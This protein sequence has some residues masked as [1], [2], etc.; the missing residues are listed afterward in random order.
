MSPRN[1]QRKDKP[2]PNRRNE[3]EKRTSRFGKEKKFVKKSFD[4][5]NDEKPYKSREKKT[6]R[7]SDDD[8][9][10]NRFQKDKPRSFDRNENKK[11]YKHRD[12]RKSYKSKPTQGNDDFSE[13]NDNKPRR[14]SK[15]RPKPYG[16]RDEKR[17]FERRDDRKS[18]K[19]KPAHDNDDFSEENDNKSKRFSKDKPYGKRDEKRSFDRRDDRKSYKS[20][21]AHGN[22]DFSEVEDDRK[23]KRF[24]TDKPYSKRGDKR[25]FDHRDDRKSYKSKPSYGKD[26]NSDRRSQG[27]GRNEGIR[28][29]RYLSNA[30]V[31]SRRE[32]DEYIKAGLVKVNGEVVT[33]L[34]TK[35][36]P[37]DEIKF[38]NELLRTEK[39][40]Y[41]LLNKPKDYVTTTDDERGRKTVMQL[42]RGACREKVFPVGRLDRNTTGVLLI[43]NDGEMSAKLTHPKYSKKKIYHVFL[44]KNIKLED[45][46]K[47]VEGVEDEG[48]MLHADLVSYADPTDKTQVG[49]EIHSGQNRVV[50]RMFEALGYRVI[51]LDRVYFAG[52]TKKG[53]PRG[54]WRFLTPTEINMLKMGA[55][56]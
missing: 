38:N 34:G 19:S 32:A 50:R 43:T 11:D 6:Y 2:S 31:C 1:F 45:M 21:P 40:V 53:L 23:S 56:E 3:D 10:P 9:K 25:D 55:F 51:K 16:K 49:V 33:E 12:D 7:D 15:D 8:Q 44:D 24:S 22:D 54:R 47:L 30:G 5:Q 20:K 4:K 17:N 52:L 26:R 18:Y 41:I 14:F 29:N 28:L 27:K 13:E 39:K 46:D 37:N 48:E 36:R 35:V 42:I